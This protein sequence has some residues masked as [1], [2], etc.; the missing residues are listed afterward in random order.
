[1]ER[2][3][4]MAASNKSRIRNG[5]V[6]EDDICLEQTPLIARQISQTSGILFNT[7]YLINYNVRWCFLLHMFDLT[8]EVYVQ[9]FHGFFTASNDTAFAILAPLPFAI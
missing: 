1:M 9:M 2:A 4:V 6:I 8:E 3:L 5:Y 7:D